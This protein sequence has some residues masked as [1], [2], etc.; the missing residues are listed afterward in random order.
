M[1]EETYGFFLK[2]DVFSDRKRSQLAVHGFPKKG[3]VENSPAVY[4]D[5]DWESMDEIIKWIKKEKVI[6]LLIVPR[7]KKHTW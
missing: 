3:D 5:T 4:I 1:F 2:R 7:W 6:A